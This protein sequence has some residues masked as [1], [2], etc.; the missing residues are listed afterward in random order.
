MIDV[1][2]SPLFESLII[3]K[4]PSLTG[5]RSQVLSVR[6][7]SNRG[8]KRTKSFQSSDK[9]LSNYQPSTGLKSTKHHV[10]SGKE[11]QGKDNQIKDKEASGESEQPVEFL[12]YY[13]PDKDVNFL[14][15]F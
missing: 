8:L 7:D 12:Y 15:I 2:I 4:R 10:F 5:S 3:N 6:Q 14:P 1:L 13:T 11:N 9:K